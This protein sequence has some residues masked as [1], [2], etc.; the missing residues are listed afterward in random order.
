MA[1]YARAAAQ[2][3]I[4]LVPMQ[5][6]QAG[7]SSTHSP[8]C[9]QHFRLPSSH[10]A[11]YLQIILHILQSVAAAL[12]VKNGEQTVQGGVVAG[13]AHHIIAGHLVNLR[14]GRSELKFARTRAK[15]EHNI[16]GCLIAEA[17]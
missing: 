6:S 13:C 12:S 17:E 11:Q 2:H 9:A 16:P 14:Q 7:A 3:Y 4:C 5:V 10:L 15:A 8:N 1:R